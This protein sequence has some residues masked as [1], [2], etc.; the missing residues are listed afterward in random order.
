MRAMMKKNLQTEKKPVFHLYKYH[1]SLLYR[2]INVFFSSKTSKQKKKTPRHA[3]G[4]NLK[5]ER[6]DY[7]FV[8][9]CESR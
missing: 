4:F 6:D 5:F 7:K 2:T 1:Y 3:G 8:C 9:F